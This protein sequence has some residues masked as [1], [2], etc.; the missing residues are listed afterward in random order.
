MAETK[1]VTLKR[2]NGTDQ[3]TLHPETHWDQVEGKPSTFTPTAH[4]LNSHTDVNASPTDGQAL[5]WD[6][7]NSLWIAGEGGGGAA[8]VT[9]SATE[10]SSPEVGDLWWDST[11]G[12]L[13]IYYDDGTSTQWVEASTGVGSVPKTDLQNLYIYGKAS[14]AIT[15]G[16]AVQFAGAEGG[17][18]LIKTA[19]QSEINAS[20]NYMVGLAENDI[21]NNAFGY[22]L[23]NGRLNMDTSVWDEGDILYFDSAG[24]TAGALT[25]TEPGD[26]NACIEMAA[27]SV[28]GV[29]NGEIL[30]RTTILT[31][32][33]DEV[34][35]LQSALDDKSDVGHTHTIS[36]VTGLQSALDAKATPS[37]ITTAIDNLVDLAPG[38]LDTLNELAAALGDDANFAGTV[39]TALAGKAPLV[40]THD[41]RY[42]TETEVDSL[43]AGKQAAGTYNTVIGT[44]ADIDTSG[45]TI[46]DN[47]YMTDGVITSHGTRTLTL[48]DLGYTGATNANNYVHP[49]YAGDDINLDTGALSGATVISDLDFNITSDTSGHITDANATYSTRNLTAANIG[50]A[51]ASHTHDDRYYTET[52]VNSLLAGKQAAGTY[53]TIIGTDSDIN[54]SGSTIIDNIYVTD[55]VITSMG[56]RTLTAGDI[57][58][59]TTSGKAADANLFDG[60]DSD[61][62][63]YGQNSTKTT[64]AGFTQTLSSGF[65]DVYGTASGAP[66]NTWYTMINAR[67]N[68]AGNNHGGQIA[69]S[70]YSSADVYTR[71]INNGTYGAWTKMWTAANDGSGSGLDADLLDGQ[72]GSYYQPA[73]SAITT[74]NIGSQSVDYATSA[75]RAYPKRVGNVDLNFNWSGQSGQPPWLWGGSDGSNMYVYNPS[76]FSVNYASSA[77]NADT[78]DG[79]HASSFLQ[80]GSYEHIT[81]WYRIHSNDG[82]SP[83]NTNY[84]N[85][86]QTF[87]YGVSS[88]VTGP[89]ISFGGLGTGYP[90]QIT[91]AYSGGGNDFKV[92]TRNGDTS[93]WNGWKTLYHNGNLTS[94]HQLSNATTA[95]INGANYA[96]SGTGGTVKMRVEGSTLYIRNDGTNA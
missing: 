4:S 28:D 26:P 41:D 64:N 53:N 34:K 38:S 16:Q 92:R 42:Y 2:F 21:A 33:I 82:T 3:D 58:A 24:S 37:D 9:I 32:T 30:V 11:E 94:L 51:P 20:P 60:I 47:L 5:I 17:H 75:G 22:V 89:L 25:T 88:G 19:V 72:Q 69:M 23:V 43:L 66:T 56:T 57:G 93:S 65:Y 73:S 96:T 52:E 68:N 54:T 31:R 74:S 18:I 59:L 14:G 70:F 85:R 80:N 91:G 39:T 8:S 40:H 13:Y 84:D 76:N 62:F 90:M 55:G 71:H 67:H 50:A 35:G 10:P 49:T 86:Y 44:D 87:N 46:I 6:G 79:V 95:F 63:I 81:Y 61:R 7:T 12:N 78:V 15:K 27:V 1:Q 45:A 77:G 48:A 29:G 36:D 83:D